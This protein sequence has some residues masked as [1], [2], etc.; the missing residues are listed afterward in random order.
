MRNTIRVSLSA[1]RIE[2]VN[3]HI[4]SFLSVM[5]EMMNYRREQV[6]TSS[7]DYNEDEKLNRQIVDPGIDVRV[8]PSYIRVELPESIEDNGARPGGIS[9][10]RGQYAAQ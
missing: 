7:G 2:S 6:M 10:S 8:R 3:T 5:R 9:V 4:N 1:A